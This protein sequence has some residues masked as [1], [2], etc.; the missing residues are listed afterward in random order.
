MEGITQIDFH[1]EDGHLI[2]A[3]GNMLIIFKDGDTS[4][5]GCEIDNSV[6]RRILSV[7]EE[8]VETGE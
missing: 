5:P 8:Q 3:C 6:L 4:K 2:Q 1:T 7:A